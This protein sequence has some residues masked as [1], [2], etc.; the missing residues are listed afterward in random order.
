M[1]NVLIFLF[2]LFSLNLALNQTCFNNTQYMDY[3]TYHVRYNY[4]DDG[5][6]KTLQMTE[7]LDTYCAKTYTYTML[8]G[9]VLVTRTGCSQYENRSL[10]EATC[11]RTCCGNPFYSVFTL[12]TLAVCIETNSLKSE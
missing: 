9:K 8:V 1:K 10:D 7:C 12:E 6:N 5:Q 2:T 4:C 3:Y 11:V